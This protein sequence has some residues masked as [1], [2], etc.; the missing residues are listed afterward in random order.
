MEK[1]NR[2]LF[3]ERET[4]PLHTL[5]YQFLL[6]SQSLPKT[7]I[8]ECRVDFLIV[9]AL[10]CISKFKNSFLVV[11]FHLKV[12][13]RVLEISPD[14]ELN[15]EVVHSLHIIMS[16]DLLSIVEGLDESIC[17]WVRK[18]RNKIN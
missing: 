3:K 9:D 11:R 8:A 17:L 15:G 5:L 10:K 6:L 13:Q 12:N 14:Q 7:T 4:P 1:A 18:G 16:E 2:L